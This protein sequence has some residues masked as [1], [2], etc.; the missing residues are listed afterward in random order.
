MPTA[1]IRK[2]TVNDGKYM[3]SWYD[4]RT[5]DYPRNPALLTEDFFLCA[6][7]QFEME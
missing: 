3:P 7:N 1:P 6:Y 5:F 4:V 2:V